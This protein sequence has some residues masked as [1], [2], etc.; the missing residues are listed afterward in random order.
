MSVFRLLS[1]FPAAS[2]YAQTLDAFMPL[3]RE[4]PARA[5]PSARP[6]YPPPPCHME[7]PAAGTRPSSCG[8]AG[9]ISRLGVTFPDRASACS[10]CAVVRRHKTPPWILS[11]HG[12]RTERCSPAR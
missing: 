10:S 9:T 3:L 1:A 2:A 4:L 8:R 7:S 5:R 6:M 12:G 11:A